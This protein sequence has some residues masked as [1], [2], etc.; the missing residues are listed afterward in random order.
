ML[1]LH[2][3]RSMFTCSKELCMP[4]L[5]LTTASSAF[6]A[7]NDAW[8]SSV[9][10]CSIWRAAPVCRAKGFHMRMLLVPMRD[11]SRQCATVRRA[12]TCKSPLLRRN[13]GSALRQARQAH[14]LRRSAQTRAANEVV[15]K[16]GTS[17]LCERFWRSCK[18]DERPQ[19]CCAVRQARCSPSATA[20]CCASASGG[21]ASR[22]KGLSAVVLCGKRDAHQVRQQRAV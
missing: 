11:A 1:S 13:S 7:W 22:M 18:Q 15:A 5:Q 17:V 16:C 8:S 21:L 12:V 20:A 4:L 6:E 2:K 9:A 14:Q 10:V 3:T 19:R